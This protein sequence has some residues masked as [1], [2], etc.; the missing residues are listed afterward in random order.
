M[1]VALTLLLTPKPCPYHPNPSPNPSPSHHPNQVGIV[2]RNWRP[3]VCV[4]DPES[5]M[6][7]Q[8]G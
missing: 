7:S 2:K 4:L 6:G 3:Y 5:A 1:L 8:V